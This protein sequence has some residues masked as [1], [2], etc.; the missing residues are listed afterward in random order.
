M[1]HTQRTAKDEWRAHWPLVLAAVLGL[2]FSGIPVHTMAFF[3][4]PLGSEFGWTRTQ[5]SI[6]LS[7]WAIVVI[8]LAPFAGAA[9]DRWGP[10]RVAVIGLFLTALALASLGLTTGSVE[11]WVAQWALYAFFGVTLKVTVWTVA[12][13]SVFQHGRG[14]ALGVTLCGTA[15]AQTIAPLLA[16]WL[17]DIVGWR[18]A[19]FALGAGWGGV[20]L[21]FLLLFFYDRQGRSASTKQPALAHPGLSIAEA[22]RSAT[23]YR[24]AGALLISSVLSIAVIT[25]KVSILNG[26]GVS[27]GTAAQ[28]AATAGLAGISGKLLA[29]WLYDNFKSSWVG[30]VAFGIP[31]LG[32]AL[33]LDPIRT[34]F[35]IVAGMILLGLGSGATLQASVYLTARHAGLRNYGKIFGA[36]SSMMSVGIGMGPIVGGLVYDLSGSYAGLIIAGIPLSILCAALVTGFDSRPKWEHSGPSLAVDESRLNDKA[37]PSGGVVR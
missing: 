17:I 15:L 23:L 29:G 16:N 31:A 11:L 8:P 20:S 13:S 25:H 21:V 35:F 4:D 24:I 5:I 6:G 37:V 12:V 3:V 27:R 30:S 28:I 1:Q 33:M 26:M 9:I 22:L 19:Y 14:M 10:R 18:A 32:F 34:P 7:I 2:S 36:M